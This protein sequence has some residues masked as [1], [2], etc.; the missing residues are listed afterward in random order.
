MYISRGGYQS[1]LNAL[2]DLGKWIVKG[3]LVEQERKIEVEVHRRSGA[4]YGRVPGTPVLLSNEDSEHVN[5]QV[6]QKKGQR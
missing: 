1:H 6:A 3:F 2:A 4:W 5:K